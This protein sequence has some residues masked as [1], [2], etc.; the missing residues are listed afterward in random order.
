MAGGLVKG[1]LERI[2]K[3]MFKK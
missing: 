3:Q 2:W 1:K